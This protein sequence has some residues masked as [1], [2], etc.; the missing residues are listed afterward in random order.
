M[1]ISDIQYYFLGGTKISKPE[2]ILLQRVLRIDQTEST[3]CVQELLEKDVTY[4][5]LEVLF[6]RDQKT[7]HLSKNL[8]EKLEQSE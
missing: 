1:F 2:S 6:G 4:E 7:N 3:A 8:K 5:E